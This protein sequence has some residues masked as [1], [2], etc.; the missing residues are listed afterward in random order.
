ME[1]LSFSNLEL[2]ML[3]I[4]GGMFTATLKAEL[5]ELK[6]LGGFGGYD[7]ATKTRIETIKRILSQRG[8]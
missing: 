2:L 3:E 4:Y 6:K 5:G 1:R 8:E 7:H